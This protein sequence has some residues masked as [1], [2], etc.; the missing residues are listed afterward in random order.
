MKSHKPLSEEEHYSRP[1]V[2][3]EIARFS[4]DRWVGVHCSLRDKDGRPILLR[5][6][7]GRPITLKSE[8]DVMQLF[9]RFYRLRPRTFYGTANIYSKLSKRSDVSS[10]KN[11]VGCMPTWDIDN[12]LASWKATIE[13]AREIHNFL[14]NKGIGSV[15]IKW[16]GKGAHVHVHQYAISKEFRERVHPLDAAYAMVEFTNMKLKDRF[17][18]IRSRTGS[19]KLSID[20]EMDRQRLFTAPLSLHKELDMV[21]VV[22]DPN[23]IDSF[24]PSF[25]SF[26]NFRHFRGWDIFKPGE[27]DNF[28]KEALDS[29]GGYL[30]ARNLKKAM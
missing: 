18:D 11:V 15:I 20:N 24:D 4:R 9:K 29:L 27:A 7:H 1:E 8:N 3:E 13:A 28:A 30:P 17:D 25:A 23:K 12:E 10:L 6:D 14:E 16:S 2:K 21:A 26:G 5:Y 22:I 19:R